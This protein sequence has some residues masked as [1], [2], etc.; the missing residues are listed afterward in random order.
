MVKESLKVLKELLFVG[1]FKESTAV[2]ELLV[3]FQDPNLVSVK[4]FYEHEFKFNY[5]STLIN[6]EKDFIREQFISVIGDWMM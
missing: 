3:G 5:L 2:V 6:H 1:A 4:S